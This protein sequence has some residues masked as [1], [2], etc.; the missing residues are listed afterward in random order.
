MLLGAVAVAATSCNASDD[1]GTASTE[2]VATIPSD[3]QCRAAARDAVAPAQAFIEEHEQLSIAEW[4]ALQPPP[5]VAG[6]Q[7]QIEQRTRAAVDR[8]CLPLL[9]QHEVVSAVNGLHGE[10]PVGEAV[11]AALK[12]EETPETTRATTASR[13]TLRPGDDVAAVLA[14]VGA[15]STVTF[16]AGNYELT[17]T[18]VVDVSLELVGAGQGETTI[19]SSAAGLALAFVGP[20]DLVVRDLAL[21]HTGEEGGSVLLAIEGAVTLDSVGL[22]GGRASE[23]TGGGHGLVFAFE[24]LPDFPERTADQREGS[25]IVEDSTVTDNAAAGI[26]V[27][28]TAAP[29]IVGSTISRNGSCGLCY[30]GEAAGIVT[31]STI[32]D[33]G[34]AGVQLA[35]NSHASIERNTV[36]GHGVGVL[37]SDASTPD[38]RANTFEDNQIGIQSGGTAEANLAEN[39]ILTAERV[40]ISVAESSSGK[41]GGNHVGAGA[42]VGIEVAGSAS[43]TVEGNIV[44]GA[45]RVGLSFVETASGSASGNIVTGRD[46][47]IQIGGSAAPVLSGNQIVDS[48]LVGVLFAGQAAGSANANTV[49]GSLVSGVQVTGTA[50]PD[51][52]ANELRGG[53]YGITFLEAAGGAATD[54]RI[55]DHRVGVQLAGTAAPRLIGNELDGIEQA[56]IV[57]ADTSAGEATANRCRSASALGIAIAATASPTLTDNEC[58]MDRAG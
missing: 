24:H 15:G 19:S 21:T 45:G 32:E 27:T 34:G 33:N 6:L 22:S 8:G 55:L 54:N 57:Y 43:P 14:G 44:E 18:L 9:I 17:E 25:L 3:E 13:T 38:V 50:H 4:N 5:D 36:R 16:E 29:R 46:I 12:G 28:G 52:S 37:V 56:A 51:I 1:G 10:G 23:E 42:P 39:T 58:V 26:F 11:A 7:E 35:G 48:Q 2:P 20:G 30:A 53:E 41:V 40:A 47:G 49:I 31:D